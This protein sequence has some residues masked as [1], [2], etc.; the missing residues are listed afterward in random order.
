MVPLA[1]ALASAGHEVAFATAAAFGPY[2]RQVGFEVFPAGPSEAEAVAAFGSPTSSPQDPELR[3]RRFVARAE[4]HLRDVLPLLANWRPQVLMHAELEM[5]GPVAAALTGIPSINHGLGIGLPPTDAG[6][7]W[8]AYGLEPPPYSGMY[9]NLYL[10]IVPPS[11]ATEHA[12]GLPNRQ[13]LQPIP[14]D[15][16]G[17]Q[18]DPPWLEGVGSRPTVYVT[19]APFTTTRRPCSRRFWPA[20]VTSQSS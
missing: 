15:D 12:P 8:R 9:R 20:C 2:V 1:R 3:R 19:L 10:D 5:S 13:L 11:L 6:S 7:L 17:D 4:A 18:P 14:F 16:P